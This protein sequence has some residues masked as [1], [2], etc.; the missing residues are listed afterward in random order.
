MVPQTESSPLFRIMQGGAAVG[1]ADTLE[2]ARAWRDIRA[3]HPLYAEHG[4]PVIERRGE[5][6][7]YR[8]IS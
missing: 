6:G 8:E 3:E 1:F 4:A 5:E 7:V 2:Y